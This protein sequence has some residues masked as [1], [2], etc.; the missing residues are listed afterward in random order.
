MKLSL[1]Q[2]M[3]LTGGI[4]VTGVAVAAISGM[5]HGWGPILSIVL[6]MILL[7]VEFALKLK[8]WRCP[9]CHAG[10]GYYRYYTYCPHCGEKID[11][12]AK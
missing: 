4:L 11:Y 12:D 1:R 2:K 9:H 3:R 6:L 8:W 10:L 5:F 7:V